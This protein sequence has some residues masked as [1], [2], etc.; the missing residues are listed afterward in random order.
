MTDTA[1]QRPPRQPSAS[2]HA[3][4]PSR[5]ARKRARRRFVGQQRLPRAPLHAPAH[6]EGEPGSVH[7][8]VL[9]TSYPPLT[10]SPNISSVRGNVCSEQRPHTSCTHTMSTTTSTDR[11]SDAGGAWWHDQCRTMRLSVTSLE[12]RNISV[13]PHHLRGGGT[14]AAAQDAFSSTS[15]R[16][17]HR[18]GLHS[19]IVR[20]IAA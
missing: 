11:I 17:C 7:E 2:R 18:Q 15:R 8:G 6:P 10:V 12:G 20:F 1:R 13:H 3:P 19:F 4:A 16:P 14:G 9:R 5:G